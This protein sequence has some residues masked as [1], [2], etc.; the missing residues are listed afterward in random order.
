MSHNL[1]DINRLET[2]SA[3][4]VTSYLTTR[5]D[6]EMMNDRLTHGNR[7]GLTLIEVLAIVAALAVMLS[8]LLPIVSDARAKS[9]RIECQNNLAMI[10]RTMDSYL[11]DHGNRFPKARALGMPVSTRGEGMTLMVTLRE[12]L[13]PIT[14]MFHC[15]GDRDMLFKYCGI[16][17]YY[18]QEVTNRTRSELKFDNEGHPFDLERVPVV[19]DA[20]EMIYETKR[21]PLVVPSF[22]GTKNVLYGD[23]HVAPAYH[24]IAFRM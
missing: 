1:R 18:S 20:D 3:V 19:W 22:H 17:Y 21:E 14:T 6:D 4:D 9:D 23:L 13:P 24:G 15:P 2:Y 16:S 12:Y 11:S 10:G 7:A 5:G 8:I